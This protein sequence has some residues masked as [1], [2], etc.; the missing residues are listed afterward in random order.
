M[1]NWLGMLSTI[2]LGLVTHKLR[3]FLTILG[4]VIGVASVIT[5]MSIGHG[6]EAQILSNIQSLGSN[7]VT[8]RP[9]A[10]V[11]F[12]GVRS[13]SGGVRTLTVEDADAIAQLPD[14]T[15]VSPANTSNQQL[16]VG[17]QNTNAHD[18]RR[19]PRVSS[20]LTT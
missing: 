4:V 18:Q 17:N 5:L 10:T 13:S 20:A 16:I 2:W 3:S 6:A 19:Q 14:I 8:I 1:K 9:G 12:G 7:L 15:A 11:S